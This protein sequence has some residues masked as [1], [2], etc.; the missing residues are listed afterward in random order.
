M[1]F[2]KCD[3]LYFD[4]GSNIGVQIRKLFEPEKYP[5]AP[6]LPLFDLFFGDVQSRRESVC[7]FGF[8]V[9]TKHQQR[10]EEVE[11]C[12]GQMGWKTEFQ[13]EAVWTADETVPNHADP[14]DYALGETIVNETAGAESLVPAVDIAE[15]VRKKV[16]Q[17]RPKSVLM[18]LKMDIGTKEHE[19]LPHMLEGDIFCRKFVTAA[20]LE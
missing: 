16:K 17:Y 18:K 1:D 7:A 8:E 20:F 14:T 10:L 19:L 6:V 5:N 9:N 4:L 2:E 12:Y 3:Y 13:M 15:F 11:A